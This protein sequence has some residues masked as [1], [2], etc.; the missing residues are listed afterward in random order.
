[1]FC[2]LK[3]SESLG[4]AKIVDESA[5]IVTVE[6]FDAP[7]KTEVRSVNRSQI[8]TGRIGVNTR[9]YVCNSDSSW[10]VGRVMDDDTDGVEVRLQG[11][12]N[13]YEPYDRVFIRWRKPISDP[14][15]FLSFGITET[16][17]FA[18]AR[19]DFRD[20]YIQQR[21]KTGGISAL[22][23]S[24][25]ELVPHQIDVVRRVLR[26]PVQRYLLA[27]EVGLGKTIEAGVI[28]RQA[29]LDDRRNH[30]I[31]IVVPKALVLQ[32]HR[33]LTERFGLGPY[34]DLSIFIIASNDLVSLNA[35]LRGATFLAIDEAHHVAAPI[36]TVH[37]LFDLLSAA[38]KAASRV[39]LLSATPVLR[40]ELGFLRMLHLLDPVVYPLADL[41]AFRS[42]IANRQT[43]AEAVAS[44]EPEN[45]LQLE[46]V[47][48]ALES[49]LPE[50]RR[51]KNLSELIRPQL[52]GRVEA[53]A[54]L[55]SDLRILRGYLSET[56]RLHRRILRNRRKRVSGLTPI[57]VGCKLL[58]VEL[59]SRLIV[60]NE[61]ENWRINALASMYGNSPISKHRFLD[62]YWSALQSLAIDDGALAQ[63][64]EA[65][66][67]SLRS[68]PNTSTFRD[69]QLLL[70]KVR[71]A[72]ADEVELIS[73]K[74]L[75][76]S[77]EIRARILDGKKIVVFFTS[78]SIADT[79]FAQL[80]GD[81]REIKMYRHD[82]DPENLS[83]WQSFISSVEPSVLFCDQSAEEGINLQGGRKTIIHF[84]LPM[85]PNRIEQRIGRIDRFGTGDSI[86]SVAIIAET[87]MQR[88]WYAVVSDGLRIFERPVSSLQYLIDEQLQRLR[89]DAFDN[90]VEGL[91]SLSN[92]LRGEYGLVATESRLI[93]QQDALDELEPPPESEIEGIADVDDNWR[94]NQ[95]AIDQWAL[96][97]LMFEITDKQPGIAM[98]PPFRF[99]YVPHG[100]GRSTLVPLSSFLDDFLGA[101]DY[102]APGSSARRPMSYLHSYRRQTAIKNRVKVLRYGSEF[103]EALKSF[104]DLDDRGR[105]YATWRHVTDK[106]PIQGHSFYF[107]LCFLIEGDARAA[108]ASVAFSNPDYQLL[109]TYN[110]I[111]RRIDS[112]F[113]P[114]VIDLWLDEEGE[115]VEPGFVKTHLSLMATDAA[116]TGWIDT[117]L[118]ASRF[119]RALNEL[120]QIFGNWK[121]RCARMR[122]AALNCMA[123]SEAFQEA[124][125]RGMEN[126][127]NDRET[128]M[129]FYEARGRQLV[130][131]EANTDRSEFTRELSI[132]DAIAKAIEVPA[133]RIDV[134][135]VIVL[136]DSKCPVAEPEITDA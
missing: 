19:N 108:H 84:D 130:G 106:S 42:K 93:D 79:V 120:P 121:S 56:Y 99:R 103:V 8:V 110:A 54:R 126:A 1:M 12:R 59:S 26:D 65:R 136:S 95:A 25:I 39:L 119:T 88:A 4:F 107:Q 64:C 28:I 114:V 33:E 118:K 78:T 80:L 94:E 3:G 15:E 49:L 129:S 122:N 98:A 102:E 47:L 69:E 55:K 117:N 17:R 73:A 104:A 6:Y 38:A 50:D 123:T 13:V 111:S 81:L 132:C 112:L 135:G 92:D 83:M 85:Q 7:S 24:A 45:L 23:S 115:L 134:A 101:I 29:V 75:V 14:M 125:R 72:A 2:K 57:R 124:V 67:H 34:L 40:N 22:L 30:K 113:P 44:I 43:L 97:T 128:S 10:A 133:I 100:S 21:G 32:W 61:L 35:N 109:T 11:G 53:D 74:T 9:I 131:E 27:D 86:E 70:E 5:D 51:V 36:E 18:R 66:L 58:V 87:P 90:G 16:P 41:S 89:L 105:S 52:Y 116:G 31:A 48:D 71:A 127:V 76:L 62:F 60:D 68:E 77:P 37:G 82:P 46:P 20:M 91:L 96:E 63:H